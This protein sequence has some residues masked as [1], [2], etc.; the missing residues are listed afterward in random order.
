[1]RSLDGPELSLDGPRELERCGAGNGLAA[2]T[3]TT[4][5][6]GEQSLGDRTTAPELLLLVHIPAGASTLRVN[7]APREAD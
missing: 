2:W 3:G 7:E 6:V 1:M 5:C 4:A